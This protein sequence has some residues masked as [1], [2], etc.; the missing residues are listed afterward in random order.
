MNKYI[1]IPLRAKRAG[2]YKFCEVK[3]LAHPYVV[4]KMSVCVCVCLS[5]LCPQLYPERLVQSSQKKFCGIYK[6]WVWCKKNLDH[7]DFFSKNLTYFWKINFSG[8]TTARFMN[9]IL[10]ELPSVIEFLENEFF[11][12]GSLG[13]QNFQNFEFFEK[14]INQELKM[15]DSLIQF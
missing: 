10:N 1:I 11:G 8:T 3:I 5:S 7:F 9:S 2:R 14:L 4:V 6:K 13:G 15:L 12:G